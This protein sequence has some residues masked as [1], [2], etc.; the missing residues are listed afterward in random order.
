M[1]Y[2]RKMKIA[3]KCEEIRMKNKQTTNK[4]LK[5]HIEKKQAKNDEDCE[6]N[7][8]TQKLKITFRLS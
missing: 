3:N 2:R 4:N 7:E 1:H 6:K 5:Q 8:D